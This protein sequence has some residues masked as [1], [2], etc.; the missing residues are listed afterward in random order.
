MVTNDP[1]PQLAIP[2]G[3]RGRASEHVGAD[4][5]HDAGRVLM[6]S[7][8]TRSVLSSTQPTPVTPPS[9]DHLD[10]G[11]AGAP[12]ELAPDPPEAHEGA[13]V[14]AEQAQGVAEL[15]DGPRSELE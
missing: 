12:E 6:A 15:D 2:G 3:P 13:L 4:V 8:S 5:A 14:A 9:R 7:S 11:L 1:I 10:V